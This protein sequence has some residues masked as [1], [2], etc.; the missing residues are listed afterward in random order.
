[1]TKDRLIIE[2][3]HYNKTLGVSNNC[4]TLGYLPAFKDTM[5]GEIHLSMF[6]DG[7]L[8][9]IHVL[10]GLPREWIVTRDSRQRA[11]KVKDTIVAGFVRNGIFFTRN[12]LA[13]DSLEA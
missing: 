10:D 6:A 5:T 13:N 7:R 12:Q 9:P 4:A 2:N 1:M 8:A 3:A 11:L